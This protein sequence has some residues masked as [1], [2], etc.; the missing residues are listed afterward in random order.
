MFPQVKKTG[1]GAQGAGGSEG[2]GV[3]VDEAEQ[4]RTASQRHRSKPVPRARVF[5][6]VL[7]SAGLSG[8]NPRPGEEFHT[9]LAG[10][11]PG[12]PEGQTRLLMP[13]A[14]AGLSQ[15]MGFGPSA[16]SVC[17]GSR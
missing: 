14:R 15:A 8:K 5:S 13:S 11:A 6:R 3:D 16:Q 12:L 7:V 10:W 17:P 9:G 4:Q 1:P 2:C